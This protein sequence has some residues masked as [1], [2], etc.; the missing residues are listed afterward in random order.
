MRCTSSNISSPTCFQLSRVFFISKSFYS[1][2]LC[3]CQSV[4]TPVSGRNAGYSD[5]GIKPGQPADFR[6]V[7]LPIRTSPSLRPHLRFSP[8]GAIPHVRR[9]A[10]SSG[11]LGPR[12]YRLRGI[13][14]PLRIYTAPAG[15]PLAGLRLTRYLGCAFKRMRQLTRE[16]PH[17][18]RPR[19]AP[20]PYF[21]DV[22]SPLYYFALMLGRSA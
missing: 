17:P 18:P 16:S 13:C 19:F 22:A 15:I 21:I 5:L 4:Q 1:S 9:F 2:S 20:G 3:T 12:G 11:V 8:L 14:V 7:A 10:S 6:H